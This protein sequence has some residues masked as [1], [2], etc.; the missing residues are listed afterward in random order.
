MD[1][2]KQDAIGLAHGVLYFY[3]SYVRFP[4]VE[5]AKAV[6]NGMGRPQS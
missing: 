3:H 6:L 1:A 5:L 2:V 4:L